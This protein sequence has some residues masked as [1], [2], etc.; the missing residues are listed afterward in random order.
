MQFA[1]VK[2]AFSATEFGAEYIYLSLRKHFKLFLNFLHL[3]GLILTKKKKSLYSFTQCSLISHRQ[4]KLEVPKF[5]TLANLRHL[6]W[7]V[8]AS[9]GESL[10]GLIPMIEA[11][12]FLQK[13]NLEVTVLTL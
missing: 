5:Q 13:F 8:I 3:Y 12:P 6:N 10:I 11:A 2:L 1:S 4:E 7:R 9:D